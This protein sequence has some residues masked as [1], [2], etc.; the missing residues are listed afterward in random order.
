MAFLCRLKFIT[1]PAHSN[2][3]KYLLCRLMSEMKSEQKKTKIQTPLIHILLRHLLPTT[4][5]TKWE[6]LLVLKGKYTGNV[7]LNVLGIY[8]LR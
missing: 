3:S 5:T 4:T 7:F 2:L 6:S 1:L 8:C